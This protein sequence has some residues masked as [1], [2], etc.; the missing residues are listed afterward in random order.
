MFRLV[1]LLRRRPGMSAEDFRAYYESRHR[2]MGERVLSGQALRYVRRYVRPLQEGRAPGFDVVME[3]DFADRAAHDRCMAMLATPD[4]AREIAEDEERLFDRAA[5]L[6][7]TV[8][9]CESVMPP[10][11]DRAGD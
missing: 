5:T 11:A 3:I 7:F 2:V 6:S 4:I 9:E 8:E 10:P 1:T